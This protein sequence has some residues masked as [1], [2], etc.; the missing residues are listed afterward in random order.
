MSSWRELFGFRLADHPS[1]DLVHER[2]RERVKAHEADQVRIN[3]LGVALG[4]ART[5]LLKQQLDDDIVHPE[6]LLP[7]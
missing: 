3:E 6:Q 2:W 5:E 4:Q 7:P 1:Y